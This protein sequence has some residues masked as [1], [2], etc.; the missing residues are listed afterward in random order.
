MYDTCV[1]TDNCLDLH[2]WLLTCIDVGASSY[3]PPLQQGT[4]SPNIHLANEDAPPHVAAD[5]RREGRGHPGPGQPFPGGQKGTEKPTVLQLSFNVVNSPRLPLVLLRLQRARRGDIP[6]SFQR[7]VCTLQ[8]WYVSK[9][10]AS[11]CCLT[12][13]GLTGSP[14]P[15]NRTRYPPLASL[16]WA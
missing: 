8:A 7:A 14:L 1:Y 11:S 9:R 6:G 2:K 5:L 15:P 16:H 12:L 4:P 13:R 10:H 3:V